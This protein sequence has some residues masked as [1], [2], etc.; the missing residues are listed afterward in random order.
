MCRKPRVFPNDASWD[1][2]FSKRVLGSQCEL[3]LR[4]RYASPEV[5]FARDQPDAQ[6]HKLSE[7]RGIFLDLVSECGIGDG[8]Q[9]PC[10]EPETGSASALE[11]GRLRYWTFHSAGR[12]AS[13]YKTPTQHRVFALQRQLP[14]I[15]SLFLSLLEISRFRRYIHQLCKTQT[16]VRIRTV[17][18]W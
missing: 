6:S 15:A 4:G 5:A 12:L 10:T 16:L 8:C 2:K 1:W 13:G 3:L 14:S 18:S 17:S 7:G 9:E 11:P